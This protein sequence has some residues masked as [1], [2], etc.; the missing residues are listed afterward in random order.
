MLCRTGEHPLTPSLRLSSELGLLQS[1][2]GRR[3]RDPQSLG[4]YVKNNI[5]GPGLLSVYN[6]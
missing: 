1:L 3:M 4:R 2:V 5:G 6:H